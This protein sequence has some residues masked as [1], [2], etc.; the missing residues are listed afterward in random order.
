MLSRLSSFFHSSPTP[1]P[2]DLAWPDVP[3]ELICPIA[4]DGALMEKP[5]KVI[6]RRDIP[7]DPSTLDRISTFMKNIFSRKAQAKVSPPT[8]SPAHVFEHKNI[9]AWTTAHPLNPTCPTC[10]GKIEGSRFPEASD[11]KEKIEKF[12]VDNPQMRPCPKFPSVNPEQFEEFLIGQGV[13]DSNYV[14]TVVEFEKDDKEVRSYKGSG[15]DALVRKGLINGFTPEGSALNS[16]YQIRITATPSGQFEAK[17]GEALR[18]G[19]VRWI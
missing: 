5:V 8:E 17:L 12:L 18:F 7:K 6:H 14:Q 4:G 2:P 3:H 16:S 10:R 1:T 15:I 11:I 13:F 9:V 19:R